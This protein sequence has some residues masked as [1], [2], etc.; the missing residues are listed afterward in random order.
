MFLKNHNSIAETNEPARADLN[1]TQDA[2]LLGTKTFG[3]NACAIATHWISLLIALGSVACTH[4][5]NQT[6]SVLVSY[7]R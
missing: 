7:R 6:T 3:R 4:T 5:S 1:G 2:A